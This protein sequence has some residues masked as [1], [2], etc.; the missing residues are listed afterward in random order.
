VRITDW[1][2]LICIPVQNQSRFVYFFQVFI[3]VIALL[4]LTGTSM[5]T[6]IVCDTAVSMIGEKEHLIFKRIAIQ[7][8]G[9]VEDTGCPLPQSL[10]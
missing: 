2:N 6:T 1:R 3:H 8:I 7:T 10:K 9:V 5:S 4:G